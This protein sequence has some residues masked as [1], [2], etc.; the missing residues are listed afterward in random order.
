MEKTYFLLAGIYQNEGRIAEAV[1]TYEEAVSKF[2]E[3]G[4][5]QAN[6]GSV[7][8]MAGFHGR[9]LKPFKTAIRLGE[10][11]PSIYESWM[12]A[13]LENKH[14]HE[15]VR[16]SR[17]AMA[18]HPGDAGLIYL[19]AR[20]KARCHDADGAIRD[21]E[22][23]VAINAEMRLEALSC[24]DFASIRTA[25]GFIDLI[26]LPMKQHAAMNFL[27]PGRSLF[28]EADNTGQ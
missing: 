26:R 16:V 23:A 10:N 1:S 9:A 7:L 15:A 4:L 17:D 11:V 28:E 21:L 24:A 2:P 8:V 12:K 22:T 25:P 20:A 14:A 18:A 3:S 6:L 19:S 27:I 13:L 5:L